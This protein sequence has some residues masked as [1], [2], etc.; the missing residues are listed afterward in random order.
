MNC[1]VTLLECIMVLKVLITFN[2]L[3]FNYNKLK[4]IKINDYA[5]HN[6]IKQIIHKH[7]HT[8]YNDDSYHNHHH[9]FNVF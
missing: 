5:L 8:R 7:K 1:V 4:I 6:S 3:H 2:K 9:I